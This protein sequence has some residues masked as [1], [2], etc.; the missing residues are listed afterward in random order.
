MEAWRTKMEIGENV[1]EKNAAVAW[2]RRP[3][4]VVT[5]NL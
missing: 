4:F 5:S 1:E 2:R 3:N